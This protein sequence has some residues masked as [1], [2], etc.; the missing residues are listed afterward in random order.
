MES[1]LKTCLSAWLLVDLSLEVKT[2]LVSPGTGQRT[3]HTSAQE[4]KSKS[5]F[6]I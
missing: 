6:D 2:L 3:L 5:M 4:V 1:S